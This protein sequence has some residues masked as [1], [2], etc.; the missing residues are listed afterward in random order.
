[1]LGVMVRALS[2]G[3]I[4][5][6]F[7][8]IIGRAGGVRM[9]AGGIPSAV[10][11][12]IEITKASVVSSSEAAQSWAGDLLVLPFWEAAE[13]EK[14]QFSASQ[15]ALDD[16]C[17]GALADLIADHEFTGKAGS[18]AVIG[19]PRS[20][21]TVRR[22]AV[23]G[24]GK[25]D[26]FKASGATKLGA[27]LA[28][29]AKEQKSKLM[30]ALLPSES[31]LSAAHQQA[32]V[33]AALLG[34]SPDTRY[35]SKDDEEACEPP[36]FIHLTY[37]PPGGAATKKVALV[38]KGL[39]FDSGGYNIKAGAGSMIEKMKFDMGGAGAVLGAARAICGLEPSGVEVHFVVAAC[40][41]MVSEKAMRPGDILTASNGKTIEVMNTDAEG[42]L[43]LADA[44][45]YAEK[46][47][48][49]EAVVDV[50][51]LTGACIVAL[52]GD[53]AGMWSDNDDLAGGSSRP[54]RALGSCSGACRW[55]PSTKSRSSHPSP[56][57]RTSAGRVAVAPSPRHSSSRNS[58]FGMVE[59]RRRGRIWTLRGR[60][61]TT[62]RAA[63]PASACAKCSC[64]IFTR[65]SHRSR[66]STVRSVKRGRSDE[67]DSVDRESR[68]G[69]RTR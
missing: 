32:L 26:K 23:V 59:R 25:A 14:L 9:M 46:Q 13:D 38:G 63:R 66:H 43:T 35:K 5:M 50:A 47:G 28:T 11:A 3:S 17:G 65:R 10:E 57:S 19:L 18:S 7:P 20:V 69:R 68:T 42:R 30:G 37:A 45:V 48:P 51:T 60:F 29:M 4:G 40:E 41:N 31:P 36:K 8:R 12:P 54:P 39:T 64:I 53:Y 22:L 1:M 34:L 16:A 6:A 15:A 61:G 33:E 62:R 24:L 21:S 27:T 44:L 55:P 56:T 67:N 2:I 49:L 52:G 58:C